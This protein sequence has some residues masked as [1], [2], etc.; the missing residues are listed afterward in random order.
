M[1][2]RLKYSA[3]CFYP[4]VNIIEYGI[5]VNC[6]WIIQSGPSCEKKNIVDEFCCQFVLCSIFSPL[7]DL[8]L[9]VWTVQGHLTPPPPRN[10]QKCKRISH[11][12]M[13]GLGS[14]PPDVIVP[15]QMF[16]LPHLPL[17][18]T[19]LTVPFVQNP[20]HPPPQPQPPKSCFTFMYP[21]PNMHTHT[22]TALHVSGEEA[23]KRVRGFRVRA[24]ETSLESRS[25]PAP[26]NHS[27]PPPPPP[28]CSGPVQAAHTLS[29]SHTRIRARTHA[30]RE[31]PVSVALLRHLH[32]R[33]SMQLL[34]VV[35][36]LMGV[37]L[38]VRAAAVLPVEERSP[39]HLNRVS[40]QILLISNW[41]YLILVENMLI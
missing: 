20:Q 22:P 4:D 18:S 30:L 14:D 10:C 9:G 13:L 17:L 25:W 34:V 36:A 41:W 3:W 16:P 5:F 40:R 31:P 12:W 37:L 19:R 11:I 32:S 27:A 33:H 1:T 21:R 29:I 35:A 38:S 6:N 8:L 23:Y 24:E 7:L 2:L 28:L 39:V 15:L 26:P